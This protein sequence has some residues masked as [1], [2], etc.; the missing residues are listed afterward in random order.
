MVLKTPFMGPNK[1]S[2]GPKSPLVDLIRSLM[3][4]KRPLMDL[5]RKSYSNKIKINQIKLF[6]YYMDQKGTLMDLI[7]SHMYLKWPLI[8]PF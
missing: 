8:G 7:I 6:G 3:A 4:L 2:Y 5:N 1:V